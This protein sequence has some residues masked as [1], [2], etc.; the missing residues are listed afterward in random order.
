M[1]ICFFLW[2]CCFFLWWCCFF[3]WWCC[4]FLWWCCFF[5]WWCCFFLWW[6]CFFLWWCCFWP[7][8]VFKGLRYFVWSLIWISHSSKKMFVFCFTWYTI[9]YSKS[10]LEPLIMRRSTFSA[11]I[12]FAVVLIFRRKIYFAKWCFSILWSDSVVSQLDTIFLFWGCFIGNLSLVSWT[13]R[14]LVI[15]PLLYDNILYYIILYYIIL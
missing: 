1:W 14:V 7:T 5:L 12:H 6:C 11:L 15:L 2:W 8:W 3:L 9:F 13:N 4:F 10:H